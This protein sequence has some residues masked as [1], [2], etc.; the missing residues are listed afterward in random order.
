MEY[1]NNEL[2]HFGVKGMKWGVRR[3]RVTTG[4]VAGTKHPNVGITTGGVAGG[5]RRKKE[6]PTTNT[7][8]YAAKKSAYDNARTRYE[9][10]RLDKK[11]KNAAYDVAFKDASKI[12]FNKARNEAR[13]NKFV[14]TAKAAGK[15]D[16]EYK[17]AKK[18]FKQAKKEFKKERNKT[19]EN[20]LDKNTF[21]DKQLNAEHR[22]NS[23]MNKGDTLKSARTKAY[24]EAGTNTAI[25]ILAMYGYTKYKGRN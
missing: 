13:G 12:S 15:A 7:N 10:A 16:Q 24:V 20:Y 11:T 25:A 19:N 18:E 14:E 22:I 1:Y 17:Q 3:K 21:W 4:G 2:Y 9:N 23:Y 8:K 6:V 5:R